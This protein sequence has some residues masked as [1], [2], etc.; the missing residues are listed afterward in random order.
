M[1]DHYHEFIP[2]IEIDFILDHFPDP[3]F[4]RSIS[5][6][7][8]E[9]RQFE[10]FSKQQMMKAYEESNFI[11]CRVN[12]YPS[13]TEYKG[14]QRYPPNFLFADLDLSS[15]R[16]RHALE[17]ALESSL[18]TIKL[19]INGN[20]TVLW[21]GNGYH[22]Y[23]PVE[24][25][26]LEQYTEFEEFEHPSTKFLKFAEQYLTN[27]KS[28]RSHNPSFKSC[29]IR[30]P[31]SVNSK[32]SPKSNDIKIIQKW[33]GYRPPI[34]LLLETFH[35]YLVNEKIKEIK[36]QKRIEKEFGIK[37]AQ[38]NTLA[39]VE[40]LLGTPI[41]DYRK[42]AISLILSPYLVNIKKL[43]YSDAFLV[44]KNWLSRCSELR[45]LDGN[46]DYKIK[47]SLNTAIRKRQLP[48][49]FSTLEM[50]NKELHDIL[51]SKCNDLNRSKR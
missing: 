31:G 48:M 49:K 28:D 36:F 15:F 26:I 16:D 27:E 45:Y 41:D 44:I 34:K 14:I 1:S 13:Y 4:P 29:M 17:R 51:K 11:D 35:M 5:T 32:C 8:S 2:T 43:S 22:I 3:V 7:K 21:T 47:Y 12:A 6:H 33:D 42:N 50:K 20:P 38:V 39:W 25:V 24:A 10:V 23:Q 30:I 40:M 18:Q 46:F 9:G 37:N 19:R